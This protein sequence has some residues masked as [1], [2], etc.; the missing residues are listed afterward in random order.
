M[1]GDCDVAV[2][3]HRSGEWRQPDDA[4]LRVIFDKWDGAAHPRACGGYQLAF[5][6]AARIVWGHCGIV[7]KKV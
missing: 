3:D 7:E 4:L 5:E 2:V 6:V 1:R